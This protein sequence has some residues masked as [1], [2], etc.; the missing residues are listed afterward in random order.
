MVSLDGRTGDLHDTHLDVAVLKSE[1]GTRAG[2]VCR[3]IQ[4]LGFDDENAA[5][6]ILRFDEWPVDHFS[7]TNRQTSS[8]LIVKFV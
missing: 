5:D 2:H 1:R 8:C 7:T 6:G 4:R 3:G